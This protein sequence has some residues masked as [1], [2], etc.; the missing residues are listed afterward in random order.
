[1][2]KRLGQGGQGDEGGRA[3][4]ADK[5]AQADVTTYVCQDFACQAPLLG[6]AAAEKAF[7]GE[8]AA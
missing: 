7:A 1:M 2:E 5:P 4:L 3:L 8:P 6:A